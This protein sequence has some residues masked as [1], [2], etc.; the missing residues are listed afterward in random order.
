M[1]TI[2]YSDAIAD[3]TL[4]DNFDPEND[5]LEFSD[6]SATEIVVRGSSQAQILSDAGTVTLP[7][8]P[9]ALTTDNTNF[10][11]GTVLVVGDNDTGTS[12]DSLGQSLEPVNGNSHHILG[13]AG[14]DTIDASTESN[15]T[16]HEI[17]GNQGGDVI[18][19]ATGADSV[20]G[21]A[22]QDA[23]T[24][25]DGDDLMYGN[26]ADDTLTGGE[27][28]DDLFGGQ[29]DDSLTG[30]AGDDLIYGNKG[31]DDLTGGDNAD[32]L[33]GQDGDDTIAA[34]AGA[35]L[36][37][38]GAGDDS[39]TADGND[40]GVSIYGNQGA[41]TIVT[42]DGD[43]SVF[44]GKD[45]DSINA[46]NGEGDNLI[47]GN[48]AAD[49][50]LGGEG[51]E[52]IF[53]GQGDDNI[54]AGDG[55]DLI[56]GNL[57]ADT[58]A[59]GST[60]NDVDTLFGGDGADSILASNTGGGDTQI[61]A[62]PGAD[63]IVADGGSGED[64][65]SGGAGDDSISLGN[66][67]E[68]DQVTGGAGADTVSLANGGDAD[69][70]VALDDGDDVAVLGSGTYADEQV[71]GGAGNDTLLK[72]DN[73]NTTLSEGFGGFEDVTFDLDSGD[74]ARVDASAYTDGGLSFGVADDNEGA[75][76]V[77]GTDQDD[78]LAG[79]DAGDDL[80]G[81]SGVDQITGGEGS[82]TLDGG[83]GADELTGGDGTDAF[84]HD[85][86]DDGIDT[87]TDF[88]VEE[89]DTLNFG[90]AEYEDSDGNAQSLAASDLTLNEGGDQLRNAELDGVD[91]GTFGIDFDESLDGQILTA[92]DGTFAGNGEFLV[93]EGA[94][95]GGAN[96]DLIAAFDGNDITLEGSG[97]NDRILDHSGNDNTLAGDVGDDT[98]SGG[99]GTDILVGGTG[100]DVLTGG[101]GDD[102]FKYEGTNATDFASEGNP[103]ETITDLGDSDTI[104]FATGAVQFADTGGATLGTSDD[105]LEEVA[106]DG[107]IAGDTDHVFFE[108]TGEDLSQEGA[109]QG[110]SVAAALDS[111]DVG[112]A[113][114][115]EVIFVLDDG[116]DSHLWYFDASGGNSTE[117]VNGTVDA[118]ELEYVAKVEGSTD[119]DDDDFDL[120]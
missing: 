49:T 28:S 23:L 6:V 21:G 82:D 103:D 108:I 58:L 45:A 17:Y 42:G 7:V 1:A 53:G 19:G 118:S 109:T 43:D 80:A 114:D 120:A 12:F 46:S 100:G 8:A 101:D 14:N 93:T 36:V 54:E 90:S 51:D 31:D 76:T 66:D 88:D 113:S 71:V 52:S 15:S 111:L 75:I 29:G 38:G 33:Y 5:V 22:D 35:D 95:T 81:G 50:I 104:E 102:V 25:E 2:N 56:Y 115:A 68:D 96:G 106:A 44:G 78:T 26:K 67:G 16:G 4:V 117:A 94:V 10:T 84:K 97:G 34:D 65:I 24:G 98:L 70:Q 64:N 39:L 74:N 77:V 85:G 86:E 99:D 110:V 63:T 61:D 89:G 20:F 73:N 91:E 27:G 69:D 59:A 72:D 62:G 30:G 32:Q 9:A 18:T 105:T 41:D 47:Y 60:G 107:S 87:V 55:A 116:S 119:L 48:N 83:A 3:P 40:D 57:G 13:L 37:Y 92:A 112:T 11:D 79:G